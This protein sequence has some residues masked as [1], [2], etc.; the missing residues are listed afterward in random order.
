M[1]GAGRD[2]EPQPS[3]RRDGDGRHLDVAALAAIGA[4]A[5]PEGLPAQVEERRAPPHVP[6]FGTSAY[7]PAPEDGE[8]EGGEDSGRIARVDFCTYVHPPHTTQESSTFLFGESPGP[9]PKHYHGIEMRIEGQW[10][11]AERD[12]KR[13]R[14]PLTIVARVEGEG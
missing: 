1:D 13:C 10:L 6:G 8:P 7:R 5:G 12:G 2:S 9:H 14:Y 4:G 3:T 11:H